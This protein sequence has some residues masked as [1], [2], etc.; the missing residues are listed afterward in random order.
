MSSC[1]VG[2]GTLYARKLTEDEAAARSPKTWYL[3]HHGV[4]HPR[5]P[6]KI[7]VVFDAAALHDGVSLNSQLNRGPDLTN[8][9]LGVLLRFRQESIVL[10]ADIQSMFLQVKVPGEI[11]LPRTPTPFVSYGGKTLTSVSP[12]RSTR[13][14]LTF[15][16]RKILRAAQTTASKEPLTITRR[17]LV[18]KLSSP[19][20][21]TFTLTFC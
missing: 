9:L 21:R 15:L 8:S 16:A 2:T 14:S 1:A 19:S 3:P 10:A 18:K 20:K 12:L 13:W 11:G 17:S 7:R 5:K 6:G 4:F